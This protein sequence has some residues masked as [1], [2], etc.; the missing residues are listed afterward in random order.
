MKMNERIMRMLDWPIQQTERLRDWLEKGHRAIYDPPCETNPLGKRCY[1]TS[2][3]HLSG[4]RLI[5]GFESAADCDA[6]HD[7]VLAQR[8]AKT[9]PETKTWPTPK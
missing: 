6:A 1:V 3:K 9:A 7:F 4:Y 5:V 8:K 2:E